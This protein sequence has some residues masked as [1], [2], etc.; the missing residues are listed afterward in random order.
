MFFSKRLKNI[1]NLKHCFFSRKNG[2]SKG[3]YNS[4]NCGINSKDNKEN[5]IQNIN[6]VSKKLN[7]E[8]K[9]IIALNQNHGNKVVC[10]NNQEDVKN[11]MIGDAIVTTLKN[12]GISVLTADCVPILFYNPK[13]KI[14]G[15]VHAGWKGALNGIIENTVNK[16]LELNS[17]IKDLVAAIGPCINHHHYEVSHDFYKKFVDQNENNQQF[18]IV[19]N[20]KKYLFNIR[21]YINTKL[22]RLGINNI[23][24]IEMDTFS[25]EENFFS[26]RRSKKN[27]DKDYGRCISVIIMT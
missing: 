1:S 18:F 4:L 6:I 15:C 16:F 22:I 17:N 10:F 23:D 5:V 7:C 8:K 25:N 20:N 3:I 11:K 13:K 14:I 2:V 24:H 21:S 19:L 12:V 27:D 26:Y 9:P